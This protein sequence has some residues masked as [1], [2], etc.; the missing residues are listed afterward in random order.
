MLERENIQ[1][2]CTICQSIYEIVIYDRKTFL[3]VRFSYFICQKSDNTEK[4][5]FSKLLVQQVLDTLP[6]KKNAKPVG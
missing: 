2:T 6:F 5:F 3:I 1:D 4:S